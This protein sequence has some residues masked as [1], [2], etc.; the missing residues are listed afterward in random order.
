MT[1]KKIEIQFVDLE[2]TPDLGARGRTEEMYVYRNDPPTP[3]VLAESG[4]THAY[5]QAAMNL[6]AHLVGFSSNPDG[7]GM[8]QVMPL[9]AEEA[10]NYEVGDKV[11]FHYR[12]DFE[13]PGWPDLVA[14]GRE[15]KAQAPTPGM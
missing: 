9:A 7:T 15:P 3:E 2:S 13:G 8:W 12:R 5:A 6:N 14:I 1:R 4:V 11:A 10:A